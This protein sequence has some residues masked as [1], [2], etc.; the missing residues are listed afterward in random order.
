VVDA[1]RLGAIGRTLGIIRAAR[2]EGLR[3]AAVVLSHTTPPGADDGPAAPRMIARE[4]AAEIARRAGLPVS[5][6]DHGAQQMPDKGNFGAI[7]QPVCARESGQ[8]YGMEDTVAVTLRAE[9][10]NRPSRPSHMVGLVSSVA[11]TL[12]ANYGKGPGERGGA[13]RE[14][15][16]EVGHPAYTMFTGDG[17]VADPITANE[18]RTYTNEGSNNFRLHNCVGEH[19]GFYPTAGQDFPALNGC[20]PAVK[21]GSGGSAG[22]P[23]GIAMVFHETVSTYRE[24]PDTVAFTADGTQRTVVWPG[25]VKWSGG[26]AP[27]LTATNGKIDVFTFLS[28]NGGTNWLGFIGGQN[29]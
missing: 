25:S 14:V 28:L 2:A 20:S 13:E 9:G 12:D 16:G 15:V 1:A 5:I 8:G 17:A 3:P 19:V 29:F 21:V 11:G 4:A 27:T 18:G 6:L 24:E 26:A 7:L 10:E 22:N 23:P